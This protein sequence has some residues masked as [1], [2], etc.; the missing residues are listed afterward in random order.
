MSVRPHSFF[1][2]ALYARTSCFVY[3]PQGY[4]DSERRY[5]VIY[6]LHGLHGAESSWLVKGEAEQTL[7]RMMSSGEL[8]PS[9]V[10]MPSD[11]GYGH[12]TFYVDWY[13]GS[14]NFEQYFLYDLIPEIDQK[15]RTVANRS[16]RAVCGL[17][18]GGFGSFSLTLRHPDTFGAAASLSGA[19]ISNHFVSEQVAQSEAARII[20]PPRGQHALNYDLYV[21][22]NERVNEPDQPQLYFS[23]GTSD[24]LYSLNTA[25][26]HH[27]DA[28]GYA[29]VYEEFDGAHTWE[30]WTEHLPDALRFIESY[31][32]GRPVQ[33]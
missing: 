23:C 24:Y 1:S 30:Y 19:L 17:S 3:L 28:I 4:D 21:R 31:L 33:D 18:M 20:G 6:L 12:G 7:D 26:H 32:N 14:G 11:G 22:A 16:H 2:A 10:V 5:P 25:Y 27:L 9:I 29:H 13:D 15:Y 8:R